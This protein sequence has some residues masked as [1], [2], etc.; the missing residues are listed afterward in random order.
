MLRL[1][2][3]NVDGEYILKANNPAY[4]DLAVKPEMRMAA[5]L[6]NVIDPLQL[7]I[8]RSFVREAIPSL[9]GET[10]NPGNWNTGHVVLDEGKTHILLVTI[11][12]QGKAEDHRY[13]DH[14]IDDHRFHWQSQNSTS[15]TNKRGR[16]LTEEQ[17]LG[18]AIHLFIRETKLH[19]GKAAPFTYYGKVRYL[20]HSGANPMSIIFGLTENHALK[21]NNDPV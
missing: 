5:R 4:D 2:T 3:R 6:K 1:L 18:T 15:P 20:S 14:W 9:F 10:F 12:K 19:A 17:K 16:Q 8:G 13:L 7:S 21:F 11:H